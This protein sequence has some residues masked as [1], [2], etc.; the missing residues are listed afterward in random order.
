MSYLIIFSTS[1]MTTRE[2]LELLRL[3]KKKY[4]SCNRFGVPAEFVLLRLIVKHGNVTG[5]E[6]E[7]Q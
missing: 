6:T 4:F 5:V 2:A 1:S 3:R 7:M